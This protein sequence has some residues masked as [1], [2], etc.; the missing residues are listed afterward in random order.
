ER[1]ALQRPERRD[2]AA[3]AGLVEVDQYVVLRRR[4]A[5]VEYR[6]DVIIVVARLA[7]DPEIVRFVIQVPLALACTSQVQPRVYERIAA[8]HIGVKSN[9]ELAVIAVAIAILPQRADG[10]VDIEGIGVRGH[11]RCAS[12]RPDTGRRRFGVDMSPRLLGTQR[13]GLR[14]AA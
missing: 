1:A 14:R 9:A 3:V 6:R 5:G 11:D 8:E 4:I 13:R 10:I 2:D 7:V 12:L